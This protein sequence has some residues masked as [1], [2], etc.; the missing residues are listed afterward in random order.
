MSST[1]AGPQGK[2]TLATALPL[3]TSPT[4]R[5]TPRAPVQLPTHSPVCVSSLLTMNSPS[6]LMCNANA[7]NCRRTRTWGS[8]TK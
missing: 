7:H 2:G 1:S 8:H 3:I 4:T 5:Q 6:S